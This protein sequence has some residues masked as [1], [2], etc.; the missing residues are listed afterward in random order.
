MLS[1]AEQRRRYASQ[2][3][4]NGGQTST[5]NSNVALDSTPVADFNI[6]PCY[7]SEFHPL[8]ARM[9]LYLQ[10][11]LLVEAKWIRELR[12]RML[13]RVTLRLNISIV[14]IG[15]GYCN[16]IQYTKTKHA[17]DI[18]FLSQGK[19]QVPKLSQRK[20]HDNYIKQHVYCCSCPSLCIYVIAFVISFTIPVK[21]CSR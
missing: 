8:A 5:D 21:P 18:G 6:I 9:G 19:I 15:R 11:K 2:Q 10:V 17:H 16:H 14:H 13:T 7:E 4:S 20:S 12:R 3:R 1:V